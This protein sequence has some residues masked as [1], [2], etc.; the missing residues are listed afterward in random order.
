M[1]T[2]LINE[3]NT[4]TASVVERVM[5]QSKLVDTLHFLADPEYKGKDMRDYV[6]MLEYRLPVS[7]KYRT[8]FLTLSDELYKNKLEYKLPFDTA[9]TSEAGVIEFQL[10]FGNIEMDAEG[11][12]TQYIRKVGP[13]EIKIV[14]VY[15]WA[16]TIPDEALNALDQRII[17][18]QA[19]L[20]AMID[21]SNT[22]MNSK[23]DNLSYK[24]DMLQLTANGSPIGNAVEIKSSGGSGSGGYGNAENLDTAITN[25]IIDEKD[26]VITKDTSEFYYIRDDKSKQAI[27]P[28]TRV[29]DSNGQANEQLNNSSD[30]YAGQTVMIKNTAGKYEPWIVQLLDTGKFAVE[31]FNTASTGFVWQEF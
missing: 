7:K 28:R 17:A 1:Y 3:D 20:K 5:Q 6:V 25:G 27:R 8:E 21:K 9:L 24:N 29:F 11:R 12:T 22:M 15:D 14:D 23:A 13:G 19:M 2:I 30:T 4:L 10:T 18:M 31:P 16:A 26:L